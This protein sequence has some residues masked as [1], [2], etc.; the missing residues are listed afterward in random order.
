MDAYTPRYAGPGHPGE[1]SPGHC[2]GRVTALTVEDAAELFVDPSAYA[3]EKTF[4]SALALLREE[5]PV[6]RVE[7]PSYRPFWALTKY[8]DIVEVLRNHQL[9]TNG[10]RPVLQT[11]EFDDALTAMRDA[12]V[13]IINLVHMDGARH[14]AV[15]AIGSEWF[16]PR[17]MRSLRHRIDELAA[18]YVELMAQSG[19]ACEFVGDIAVAYPGY[20][21]LSLLGLPE[22]DFPR[23]IR[24]TQ[25]L[26]GMDDDERRRGQRSEDAVEVVADFNE[27]FGA[28]IADRRANPTDDITSAI[29]NARVDGE[30]LT[31]MEAISYCQVI[32]AAGHDTTKAAI[33]GGLLALIENP[34]ELDR[35]SADPS[36]MPTAVEEII[37]WSTPVKTFMRNANRDTVIRGVS[38]REGESVCLSYP[39]ANRDEDAFTDPWRFDVGRH[40]NRHLGFGSGV[41]FCL[42]AA[43]ARME[44][45]A[46]FTQ[47]VPRLTS[48]E[49]AGEPKFSPTLF[50]GGL[51]H[52]PVRYE[53]R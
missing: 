40:P 13:G 23:L 51:K 16:R 46:F 29:A 4:M 18:H 49:S 36:L 1:Q 2:G 37:R 27:Y 22:S 11:R 50:V 5:A 32:A 52:L 21:I 20:V 19:P 41:H 25:E 30:Y 35:L 10:P 31:D 45:D 28:V 38:I 14:R 8:D 17:A 53:M 33:A 39:S 43:L 6:A 24:W 44:I 42:G 15:R 12:G 47:L 9:W 26:F 7:H 34:S 48:I 3:D